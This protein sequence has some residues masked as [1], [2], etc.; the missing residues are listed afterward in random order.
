[1]LDFDLRPAPDALCPMCRSLL[2][3]MSGK[4][5]FRM[6]PAE[7]VTDDLFGDGSGVDVTAYPA[8]AVQDFIAT[9]APCGC[10]W[11]ARV[12]EHELRLYVLYIIHS[13]AGA[14]FEF[15]H[16]QHDNRYAMYVMTYE[17]TETNEL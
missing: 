11:R 5:E 7:K 6:F 14:R 12:G 9:F 4:H 2:T 15:G 13:K 16:R 10:E 1:M 3:G 8:P 17:R